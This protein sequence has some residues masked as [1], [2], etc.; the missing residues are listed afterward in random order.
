MKKLLF[1][2]LLPAL[3]LSQYID[4]V[5]T[6]KRIGIKNWA[7]VNDD[8]MGGISTSKIRINNDGN[9][10]FSGVLS[11]KNNGGF[12]SIRLGLI[13]SNLE[14]VKS[15]KIK[16][17][18]DGKS[19]KLRLRQNNRRASYSHS[20]KSVKGKWIEKNILISEFTPTWR[21]ISYYNYPDLQVEKINS[22]GLQI[23]DKQKGK[24]E[25]ELKYIKAVY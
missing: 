21:G 9:I 5:N 8:V 15:L 23:S 1:L 25:F 20:F 13:D 10:I 14:K 2:F 17:R 11:L 19:Y 3:G 24:F 12:A 16:F 7:K 6:E 4:I 18:G 22:V